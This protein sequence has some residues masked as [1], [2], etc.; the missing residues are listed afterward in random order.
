M[1]LVLAATGVTAH[2]VDQLEATLQRHGTG[3]HRVLARGDGTWLGVSGRAGGVLAEQCGPD[4]STAAIG[5]A[6][7]ALEHAGRLG[8]E[9]A[10]PGSLA[11]RP[12]QA[13]V[14]LDVRTGALVATAGPGNQGLFVA[15]APEGGT[16]VGSN[17]AAVAEAVGVAGRI[18]RGA[19]DFL[20]GFGF[21]PDDRTVHPGVRSLRASSVR[22][23]P[24]G[25]AEGDRAGPAPEPP[26][27]AVP[28][29]GSFDEAVDTLHDLYLRTV[30]E[31]AG[32]ST[33]HA[34]LLGGFDSAL[35]SATL[36]RLGHDVTTYT[37][38]FGDP[39]YEQRN[40]DLVTRSIGSH[41]QWVRI[42][43]DVIAQ[44]LREFGTVFAQPGPQP[45]YQLHT[46]HAARRIRDDG[47][48]HVFTG[49][50][51]DAV[52][53]G[54]PMVNTRARLVA[55]LER[56]PAPV[57]AL[58]QRAAGTHVADRHLG[59]VAR[60][61]RSVLGNLRLGGAAAGHLPTCYLDD[62]A[63]RRLRTGAPPAQDE[64]VD[65]IR[66][67]LVAPVAD[68]DRTRLAFHGNAL[69]GQSRVKVMGAVDDTGVSQSTPFSHPRVARFVGSLPLE[70]LRPQ[71]SA[72]GSSGKALLLEMT[73]R[74]RLLPDAV[75]DMPKQSP[76]DSPVDRWYTNELRGVVFELLEDLPFEWDRGYVEEILRPRR[77]ED[78]YRR[79]VSL[80][81]H[82]F[83]AVGLLV[84]YASFSRR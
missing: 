53:L 73:R 39:T 16:V 8:Q 5:S 61:S 22:V 52:F 21:L 65:E 78:L 51:C 63:L 62:V 31:Q 11:T 81:H 70:Y 67:R 44:G 77:V 13:A 69:T 55:S 25:Q 47:F 60:M 76:V 36:R 10:A 33:S 54:Y 43:P 32:T 64:A 59:H 12:E 66:R 71:G 26:A 23:G 1:H 37:F 17:L 74:H 2:R 24:P 29:V 45:H 41:E 19:E 28:E 48:S 34:V 83:Q 49:D 38:G 84:A 30:E 35:V 14:T 18:D 20:L 50:G 72:A 7:G 57:V 6:A 58:A 80:G 9:L 15:T 4:R 75:I 40:V 46:L 27:E 56:V 42:T 3:P 82:A 68:L 79:R